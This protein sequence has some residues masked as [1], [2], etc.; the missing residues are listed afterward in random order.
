MWSLGDY[1][2]ISVLLEPYAIRLAELSRITPGT[3]VLDVAAGNGNFALAAAR[4]G[5]DATACDL[6]PRMIELGRARSLAARTSIDWMEADAERLPFEDG[7]FDRVA[8][9]F[10]AMFAPRPDH[11]AREL[12]R[13]CRPNGLVS[14][15]NY[16]WAG[17]LGSFARLLAAYSGPAPAELPQ[18]FAWGDPAEVRSRFAGLAPEVELQPGVVTMRFDSV[19]AGFAFFERTNG[20]HLALKSMIPAATYARVKQ[21]TIELMTT[22]NQATDGSLELQSEYLN[23]IARK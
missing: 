15:A 9:V 8:S 17:Y 7:A 5:A 22:L 21:D 18:P 16:C 13:V 12:F 3:K 11:V 4:A 23:V 1:T 6:T 14:M 2:E 10:G 20:P 19:D